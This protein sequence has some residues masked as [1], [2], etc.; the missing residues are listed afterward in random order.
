M[1]APAP[2]PIYVL[3]GNDEFLLDAHRK[4]IL[5]AVLGDADPQL[6]LALFDGP[7]VELATVL[8]ELRT[9][10]FLA[11][12]RVVLIRDADSF[13]TANR[14]ALE[15]FLDKSP[16]STASLILV[17]SSWKSNMRLYKLV[18]KIGVAYNCSLDD[19][20]SLE[21]RIGA[22]A[23]KRGKKV[24]REAMDLLAQCVGRDLATLE[25]EI[26]KLSLYAGDRAT[27]E[28]GDVAALV[29]ATA[30]PGSFDLTNAL[31]RGDVKG[32]LGALG[33]MLNVRGDE[34][35]TLGMIAWHLRRALAAQQA[36]AGG[37]P[38]HQALPR[39]P[40]SEQEAFKAY[41]QRRPSAKLQ[42]D[43]RRLLA[44]D[45]AMKTGAADAKGAMEDLVLALCQG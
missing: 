21:R 40:F 12:Y 29:S 36:M 22:F 2:K 8:D 23:S 16:P 20:E 14:D 6:A 38:V 28:A 4:E 17:V 19:S 1:A 9:L 18:E 11:S 41:L 24:S 33:G 37:T 35:K 44:A 43:F 5:S 45:L 32:A 26:E 31:T 34:F 25:Q 3:Y 10:P 13:V 42:T 39:M 27:I 7:D 30:G 15:K